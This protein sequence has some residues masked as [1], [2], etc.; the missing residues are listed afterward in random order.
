[1]GKVHEARGGRGSVLQRVRPEAREAFARDR[2]AVRLA[3]L[4]P[5]LRVAVHLGELPGVLGRQ[6]PL[7][8]AVDLVQLVRVRGAVAVRERL[9][10]GRVL[11]SNAQMRGMGGSVSMQRR[12]RTAV[13]PASR[14][15]LAISRATRMVSR[16]ICSCSFTESGNPG[17]SMVGGTSARQ[18]P[19][20]TRSA[21]AGAAG[22]R[23]TSL[24]GPQG[25]WQ[26]AA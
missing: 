6:L 17:W 24:A 21:R 12:W 16:I 15:F 25:G 10:L 1:M 13:A 4:R 2:V 26:A 11:G 9:V 20:W 14:T 5:G 23:P 8:E 18:P 22:K 7:A 3:A 19:R